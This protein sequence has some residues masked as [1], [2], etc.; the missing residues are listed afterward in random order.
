MNTLS[1]YYKQLIL[2]ML[3]NSSEHYL[4]NKDDVTI[5]YEEIL[6]EDHQQ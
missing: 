6:G 1:C 2:L 5:T 3:L 4:D